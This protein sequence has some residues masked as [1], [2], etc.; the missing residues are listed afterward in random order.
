[1]IY[2]AV[3]ATHSAKTPET[4]D[5]TQREREIVRSERE[6]PIQTLRRSASIVIAIDASRERV[7]CDGDRAKRRPLRSQSRRSR[8]RRSR[9]RLID[10]DLAFVCLDLMIFFWVLF[11]FWGMNDIMYSFGNRENVSNKYKMCFLR[12]FQEHNQTSENIFWNIFWNATK[13]MKIF[14]F[15]GK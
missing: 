3:R 2:V 1:M 13:H 4:Q 14:F 5:Q 8:S 9:S 7:D 10:R 15:S 12:Y 6:R 11:V